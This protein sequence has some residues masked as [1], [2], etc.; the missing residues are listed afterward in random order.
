M[1]KATDEWRQKRMQD[2][3]DKFEGNAQL[4]RALGYKSGAYVRQMIA[5]ERAITE[6]TVNKA[7]KL[8]DCAGWFEE[9]GKK[10]VKTVPAPAAPAPDFSDN[11]QLNAEQWEQFQAFSIAAT[12]EEKKQIMERYA[13]L[14]ILADQNMERLAKSKNPG[15]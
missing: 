1:N 8:K 2:L 11:H 5:G 9:P 12:S 3:A 4:G 6:K 14:K 7:H 13:A 15:A 10:T